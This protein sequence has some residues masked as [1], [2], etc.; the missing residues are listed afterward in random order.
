VR[1]LIPASLPPG[2]EGLGVGQ[3]C[4]VDNVDSHLVT[5]SIMGMG[6]PAPSLMGAQAY[7]QGGPS[8][9]GS[10]GRSGSIS[11]FFL[12]APL[13]F[14]SFVYVLSY[15]PPITWPCTGS[16]SG[17]RLRCLSTPSRTAA[18]RAS[19]SPPRPRSGWSADYTVCAWD[20]FQP[21]SEN[22]CHRN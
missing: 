9:T 1:A 8:V 2:I 12:I 13:I 4:L 5:G 7:Q 3:Q 6:P 19:L 18:C 14:L 17:R 15:T 20:V 11:W 10:N 16:T 21:N 22:M